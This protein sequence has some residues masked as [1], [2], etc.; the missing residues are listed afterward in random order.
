MACMARRT[1]MA[2]AITVGGK[3]LF[4]FFLKECG[5]H[6]KNS[7]EEKKIK[8][9]LAELKEIPVDDKMASFIVSF[10]LKCRTEIKKNN[11]NKENKW[12]S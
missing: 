4:F 12:A 2:A 1:M 9:T 10:F 3:S 11:N 5:M 8:V 6:N 7:E